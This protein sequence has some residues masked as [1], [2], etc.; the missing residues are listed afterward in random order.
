[1]KASDWKIFVREESHVEIP[2][3]ELG[4]IRQLVPT[5]DDK[6][7]VAK[8][9]RCGCSQTAD[10][11]VDRDQREP[12]NIAQL[13]LVQ[14]SRPRFA[15]SKPCLPCAVE[16]FAEHMSHPFGRAAIAV[17]GDRL[18]EDRGVDQSFPPQRLRDMSA[19]LKDTT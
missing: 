13:K 12:E 10:G 1:M 16:Q 8:I 5:D 7:A 18:A 9:H 11:T 19:A 15:F 4:D 17:V 6:P 2:R 14:R 3:I